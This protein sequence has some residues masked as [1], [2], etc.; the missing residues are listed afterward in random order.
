MQWFQFPQIQEVMSPTVISFIWQCYSFSVH[1]VLFIILKIVLFAYLNK[2]LSLWWIFSDL[3]L[4]IG[5]LGNERSLTIF[6][7]WQIN[8]YIHTNNLKE[9][10]ISFCRQGRLNHYKFSNFLCIYTIW[11]LKLLLRLIPVTFRELYA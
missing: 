10:K 9:W 7:R 4:L 11:L 6:Y 1:S 5:G 3:G 2:E 8:T